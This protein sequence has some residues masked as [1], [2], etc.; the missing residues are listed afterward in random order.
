MYRI[1][2]QGLP[3]DH[4]ADPQDTLLSAALRSEIGFPYECNSGG[5][6]AC[7]FELLEGEVEEVWNKAPGLTSRDRRKGKRL[8]CQ[9]RPKSDLKIN[10]GK[11]I[12]TLSK[13]TPQL[14]QTQVV[15]KR[16]VSE[17]M[18]LLRLEAE[19]SIDF[20]PGQYFMFKIPG[21]GVRAYSAS[22]R[23]EGKQVSF[24]I[25]MVP[26]GRVSTYLAE[27]S[28]DQIQIDGPYGMA[29]LREGDE[30]ASIFVAGGSGIAPMVSM[31]NTLIAS[32]YQKPIM[33]FYGSRLESELIVAT[34]LFPTA[35]NLQLVNVLSNAS[36]ESCWGGEKGFIHEV[37]PK[38]ITD[39]SS[40]E[41]YLCGPAPM[42]MA[43]QKLLMIRNGVKFERIHFDRFF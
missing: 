17:E 33:I 2:Y 6:G 12:N 11:R 13:Y 29:V 36:P 38:Y 24:L 30:E 34:D 43:T 10:I 28:P 42:I 20:I 26:G 14:F 16:F 8:A 35:P 18:F 4:N 32:D 25:K 22:N 41:F 19:Q 3:I 21:V 1:S 15:E 31:V 9:C 7:K 27:A 39:Y 40:K 37:I 5:C 23:V